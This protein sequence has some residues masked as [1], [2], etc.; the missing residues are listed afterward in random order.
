MPINVQIYCSHKKKRKKILDFYLS[1]VQLDLNMQ[2]SN[3][4]LKS[5]RNRN[6]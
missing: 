4:N 1:L 3:P 5:T 2:E 6:I